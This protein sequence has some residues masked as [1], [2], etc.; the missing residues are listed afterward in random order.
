MCVDHFDLSTGAMQLAWREERRNATD[1]ANLLLNL[2]LM[3]DRHGG[4]TFGAS[5]NVT[6]TPIDSPMLR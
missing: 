4:A 6:P 3:N 2:H 1:Q 5:S